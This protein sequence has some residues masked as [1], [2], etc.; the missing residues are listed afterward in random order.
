MNK[1]WDGYNHEACCVLDDFDPSHGKYLSY[2][3]KIWADHYPFNAEV[4]GGMF[5]IRP[6]II[7]VTSQYNIWQCFE[8][9]ET[10]Q[11]ITRRFQ[12][13]LSQNLPDEFAFEHK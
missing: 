12:I 4:K 10:I 3:L 9:G 5:E 8:D 11:A 7:I 1:W 6:D 2:F 13:M